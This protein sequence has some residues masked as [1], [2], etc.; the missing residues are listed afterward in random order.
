MK[1]L[2]WSAYLPVV[3]CCVTVL[4]VSAAAQFSAEQHKLS[5]TTSAT[6]YT[7]E[8]MHSM[9][10]QVSSWTLSEGR[11]LCPEMVHS[12]NLECQGPNDDN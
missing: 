3:L 7:S 6:T 10:S 5:C 11:F 9:S 12:S 8:W 2:L 4:S 1:V